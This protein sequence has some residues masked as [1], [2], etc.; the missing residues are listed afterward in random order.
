MST[1]S[2]LGENAGPRT[3]AGLARRDTARLRA[4][5]VLLVLI[6]VSA[7]GVWLILS[8]DAR[9]NAPRATPA[10]CAGA[11]QTLTRADIRIRVFNATTRN[12]LAASVAAQ[13]RQRGYTV[14]SIGNDESST[15]PGPASTVCPPICA[16][17]RP[18]SRPTR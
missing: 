7:L 14:I 16:P 5:A 4:M 13:L 17:T 1:H 6:A 12:G 11:G 9:R 2:P 8:L 15:V 18:S 10:A 3:K